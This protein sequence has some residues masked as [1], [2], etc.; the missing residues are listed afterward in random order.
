[1]IP[2]PAPT[3]RYAIALILSA[4]FC[5]SIM[6]ATVKAVGTTIGIIPALWAR[7]GGQM[8]VVLVLIAPRLRH[9]IRTEHLALQLAR[10]VLLLMATALFFQGLARIGLAEA[11]AVMILNPLFITLGAVLFLGERIGLRRVV[12]ILVAFAGAMLI[13]RPGGAAFEPAALYPLGAAMSFAGYALITRRVG[14]SEDP[15][16]SLFYT[17]SVGG[18][19]TTLLLPTA[20]VTPTLPEA[21][22]MGVIA[23]AGTLGQLLLIRAYAMA[24][25]NILAPFG[26]AGVLFATLF[27][28]VFFAELPSLNTAAG[29]LVIVLAGLYVWLRETRVAKT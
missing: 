11:T 22:L 5:F 2:S 24:E 23:L 4:I 8:V 15:W 29:A 14:R 3:A 28:L 16:T 7:Y 17:A 18:L 6:D 27:G 13:I 12:A 1:M 21:G 20:W 19:I 9:V 26:Y 25:A 10:S